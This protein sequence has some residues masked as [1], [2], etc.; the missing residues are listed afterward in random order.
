MLKFGLEFVPQDPVSELVKYATLAES[1]GFDS[2]WI[3]DHYNNRGA[4][5]TLAAVALNTKKIDVGIGVTNPYTRNIAITA[6]E[7]ATLNELSGGRAILGIGAGDKATFTSLGIDWKRPLTT[8]KE[9]VEVL[10]KLLAGERVEYEGEMLKVTG[11]LNFKPEEKM[12]IYIGAQGPKML[13]LAGKVADGVL[14][15]AAHPKDVELALKAVA[16]PDIDIAV[17]A[18]VSVDRKEDNARAVA[19]PPVAFIAAGSNPAILERHGIDLDKASEIGTR[20]GAGKFKDAFSL[21][22]NAMIDAFSVSGT[23]EQVTERIKTLEEKGIKHFI[24]GSPLGTKKGE[25]I[26]LLG[27]IKTALTGKAAPEPETTAWEIYVNNL[28]GGG[29]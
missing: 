13:A 20:L 5:S 25:A 6:S 17:Y 21:V 27:E 26:G 7:I 10:R 19:V 14:I 22:D 1:L 2:L 28:L 15:N 16:N 8:V 3:T 23:P 9:G 29:A 12:R 11:K 24:S 4:Y 18:S